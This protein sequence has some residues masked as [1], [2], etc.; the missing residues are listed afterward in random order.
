MYI[1]NKDHQLITPQ[2]NLKT[3]D[4]EDEINSQTFREELAENDKK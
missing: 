3:L 2:I 1:I 4:L